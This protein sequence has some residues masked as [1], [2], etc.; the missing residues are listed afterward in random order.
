MSGYSDMINSTSLMLLVG[1]ILILVTIVCIIFLKKG[2][3]EAKRLGVTDAELKKMVINSVG[4]SLVPS[5][6]IVLS[7]IVMIP[8]LGIPLPWLRTSVIGSANNELIAATMAAEASGAQFTATGMTAG[9]WIDAAWA[10]TLGCSVALPI[11]LVVLKPVCRTYETF[12]KKDKRW[13]EIFSLCA[14]VTVIAAFCVSNAA[15]GI[16]PTIVILSCF[17]FSYICL[18]A[19]KRESLRWLKD[20][21]FPLT[22]LV[23]LAISM[24]VTPVIG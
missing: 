12:R 13:I 1:G 7:V 8:V 9:A 18:V 14:L 11:V 4:I 19:A 5:I 22:I 17:V 3:T 15:K 24:I 6:P 2:W 16:V 20:Y 21:S 23:G 10:M